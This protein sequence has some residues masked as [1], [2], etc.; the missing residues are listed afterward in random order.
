[1]TAVAVAVPHGNRTADI[2]G[3]SVRLKMA[4][5]LIEDAQHFTF[6][7]LHATF[8]RGFV[9]HTNQGFQPIAELI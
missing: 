6:L 2:T 7:K 8:P 9:Y 4:E 1:M 3:R 5:L